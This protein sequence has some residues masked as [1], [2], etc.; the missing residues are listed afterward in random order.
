MR[1]WGLLVLAL[2]AC[3]TAQDPVAE[4]GLEGEFAPAGA[5]GKSDS[6]TPAGG[7][8]SLHR[9]QIEHGAFPA[10]GAAP[11][12]I[13]YLPPGFVA[14]PPVDV[15]VF[16]H[17]H[18]NCVDTVIGAVPKSCNPSLRTPARTAHNLLAQLDA[19]KKNAVLVVPELQR[20]KADSSPGALDEE[21]GLAALLRDSF[22][23]VPALAA[24][25]TEQDLGG[26]QVISHSGGY[27]AAAGIARRG[28]H[29]V[30]DLVLL[31][32]LYGLDDEFYGWVEEWPYAFYLP[33]DRRFSIVY[34]LGAGTLAP[35]QALFGRFAEL[36]DP[37]DAKDFLVDDRTTGTLPDSAYKKSLIGKRTG[38]GHDALVRFYF[39]KLVA[40]SDL[41]SR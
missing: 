5:G 1:F 16:L 3:V 30:T 9:L 26:L 29:P 40:T 2:S 18:L 37:G 38:L 23:K 41:Q 7:K 36:F 12:V 4:G 24:V 28:G 31:D 22:A 27:K 21:G 10:E 14:T 25:D 34:S 35:S 6:A 32:S 20:D 8:G 39:G 13:V 19:T 33:R 15:V 11:N 17:G